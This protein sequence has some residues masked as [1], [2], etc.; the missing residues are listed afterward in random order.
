[1]IKTHK[2]KT[3]HKTLYETFLFN[4]QAM[5]QQPYGTTGLLHAPTA[6]MEKDKTIMIGGSMIDYHIYRSSYWP[7]LTWGKFTNQDRS[8]YFR[9]QA[10]K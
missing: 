8:F 5:G 2:T 1:M 6:E 3:K 9:L 4:G 7:Q 10:W